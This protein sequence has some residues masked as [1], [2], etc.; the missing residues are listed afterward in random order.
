MVRIRQYKVVL[1]TLEQFACREFSVGGI[2]MYSYTYCGT[3]E[4]DRHMG[5]KFRLD[6]QHGTVCVRAVRLTP[7]LPVPVF[8]CRLYY[9]T[10]RSDRYITQ[11]LYDTESTTQEYIKYFIFQHI[12][13]SFAWIDR[14]LVY[15]MS[16]SIIFSDIKPYSTNASHMTRQHHH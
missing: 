2:H 1:Q 11:I 8:A 7:H 4:H 5:Q 3:L 6:H 14:S 16:K 9:F 10:I 13:R 15:L 12:I